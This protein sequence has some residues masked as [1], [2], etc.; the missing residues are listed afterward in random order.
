[1]RTLVVSAL[2]LAAPAV[3]AQGSYPN[4]PVTMLV[5]FAPGGGTDITARIIA[6]HLSEGLGQQVVVENR[7]GAGGNIATELV[8]K[9]APDGYVIGL[10]S[11][12]P[13]AV[14]PHMLSKLPYDPRVDLAPIGLAVT[15]PNV[16]VVHPSLAATSLAEFVK[17]AAAKPG[18]VTYGSSGVG[19]IGHLAGALLGLMARVDLVHV[20][21]KGGSPAMT[22]LLGGQVQSIFATTATGLPHIKTGKIRALAVTGSR[23]SLILPDVPT[24]AESGYPGY[25][26]SNWY[27]YVAPAKSPREI[28]A[29]LNREI[30]RALNSVDVREQLAPHGI[31]PAPST[32]D[33]LARLI[34]RE[35]EIWGRVVKQAGL[36]TE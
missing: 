25:E 21:Y 32:P 9:A 20:P 1:M 30:V 5:G 15:L 11:V 23:R 35:F 29:R 13:L 31:E 7:P 16:L 12:G 3:L 34:E 6:R 28:I 24:V 17:L 26:A 10:T 4:R 8:A 18:S 2:L 27:A 36:K 19:G 33:E 14:A 22:D